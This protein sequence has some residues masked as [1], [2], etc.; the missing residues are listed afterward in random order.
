M[1]APIQLS[2]LRA[3]VDLLAEQGIL[4]D[5]DVRRAYGASVAI[6]PLLAIA[7]LNCN[8]AR[9][10]AQKLTSD[11][12][13]Q[14]YADQVGLDYYNINPLKL[15][16]PVITKVMAFNFAKNHR[17]LCVESQEDELLIATTE[18][19]KTSWV[20]TIEQTLKKKVRLVMVNPEHIERYII[21]FYT[22]ARSV[23]GAH[24]QQKGQ[25][26][27]ITNFEQLLE[28]KGNDVNS[29]DSHIVNI[30]DWLL[31]YAF[32]QRAS[33]I[34]LE[35][36]RDQGKVRFRID[37]VLQDV[38]EM[39]AQ[40][41][42]AVTSRL[43]VLG[44]MDVSERRKPQDGR[45]KTLS[46]NQREV[47]LRLSTL[48]TAFGEKM[49]MR[50]FDPD[51]LLR[52]FS[53]MG[54]EGEDLEQWQAL[55][56]Q[57]SGIVLVTGPTG[58]G[59][60]TTLYTSLRRL[61]TREVNVSTLED[62]IEMVVDMFNQTQVQPA[63]DLTFAAGVRTL[64][65]QDPDIIMVGEIRDLETAEMAVQAAL[66][67]HLVLSTLHTNDAPTAISRLLDLG[68][69]AHLIR[70]TLNGVMAQR[71]VRKLC[72]H[73]KQRTDVDKEAWETLVRPFK[74]SP[75][76]HLYEPVGCIEC[77]NTGYLGRVGI[78]ELLVPGGDMRS[79]IRPDVD[80]ANIRK[81]AFKDGCLSLRL[82]GAKKV[83]A[84]MTTIAEVMRVTP[85]V[86]NL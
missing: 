6:H 36:A 3:I 33:D 71:L 30:V 24:H 35:P 58:S 42:R 28:I 80:L 65:R 82:A 78:Y 2:S 54:L 73:C 22:L 66:T 27:Q 26:S 84:G 8:D 59:K 9:N 81:Q 74:A 16:V 75:P 52:S 39:P 85:N 7:K 64:L 5:A 55:T 69:P 67:G 13:T 15:D 63:I 18:P 51:V 56:E 23:S 11:I 46:P 29:E 86:D 43:K 12:L 61:A 19:Y 20:A 60:T 70:V 62:P 83:A 1:N 14:W 25:N 49:V 68:L 50:I 44:R 17:I 21:E 57:T 76:A 4:S 31:Q 10:D 32:E 34:H 47:E 72:D 41:F 77:R 79:L 45:I 38:Y 37:G 53:D 40:V 48:P